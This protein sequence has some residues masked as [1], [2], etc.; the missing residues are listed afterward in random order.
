MAKVSE[1]SYY[2]N[3]VNTR[4]Y[5]YDEIVKAL[6]IVKQ[7]IIDKS[8]ILVGGMAIDFAL[9]LKGDKIYSDNQLPDYDFYSSTHIDDAYE[10]ASDLCKKGFKN[11]S[12]IQAMHL[13]TMKVRVDFEVVADITYCPVSIFKRVPYLKYGDIKIVHPHYQMID[14]HNALSIPF[15][16]PGREVIFHRWKK[17]MLRYDKL[18]KYYPVVAT[19]EDPIDPGITLSMSS[20][21]KYRT[22]GYT[23]TVEREAMSKELELELIEIEIKFSDIKG[24]CVCGWGGIG[25]TINEKNESIIMKIPNN[26]YISVAS[27]DYK[28]FVKTNSLTINEYYSEYFGQI[29]RYVTCNTQIKDFDNNTKML[30][31]FDT[32][33]LL[34]SAEKVSDKYDVYICNTQWCMAYLMNRIFKPDNRKSLFT[35]EERYLYCR[36]LVKDGKTPVIDVYGTDNFTS[37]YINMV[38]R[39][40]E[41]IYNIKAVRMQPTNFY[42]SLPECY[43]KNT[44]DI[45]SSQY[46][47]IDGRKLDSFI[48]FNINPYPE[49]DT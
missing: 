11:I 18:Y 31:V 49:Y 7:F 5:N 46:F 33:G 21:T 48:E 13:T 44:F 22:G 3:L 16:N 25:Y 9:K 2:D 27:H 10:L 24:G 34:L 40:K 39:N 23:R 8:L 20:K 26:E 15:E 4:S 12:C 14:Q 41:M 29:P 43:R 36:E 32:Y 28:E 45:E 35:A 42:P 37:S 6:D 30:Q 19:I 47:M 38:K 1:E 17:D